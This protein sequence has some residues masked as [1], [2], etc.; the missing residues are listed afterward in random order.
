MRREQLRF[1]KFKHNLGA[2]RLNA[3]V[4]EKC[5]TVGRGEAKIQTKGSGEVQK[6]LKRVDLNRVR[7][8]TETR[9][10]FV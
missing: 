6:H 7:T 2:C 9:K 1:G 3:K 4:N 5:Y 10:K 8:E